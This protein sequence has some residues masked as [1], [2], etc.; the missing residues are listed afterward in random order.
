[1]EVSNGLELNRTAKSGS[2]WTG[3]LIQIEYE[4]QNVDEI[5][6]L[7]IYLILPRDISE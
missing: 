6:L 7:L 1:M 5:K 3:D 2:D 4:I